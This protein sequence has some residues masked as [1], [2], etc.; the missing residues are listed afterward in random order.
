[1]AQ[2]PKNGKPLNPGDRRERLA[3]ELRANLRK[4]KEQARRRE[5]GE[6]CPE[7]DLGKDR[8]RNDAAKP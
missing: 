4:R 7:P 1:M 8:R 5:S 3:A 6:D 2:Q